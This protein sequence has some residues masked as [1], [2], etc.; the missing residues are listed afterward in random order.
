MTSQDY[1]SKEES[2]L[3]KKIQDYQN[4]TFHN[5]FLAPQKHLHLSYYKDQNKRI[6]VLHNKR[7]GQ[8]GTE[9]FKYLHNKKSGQ[10]GTEGFKFT[11]AI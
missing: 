4:I 7:S 6:V 8:T 1:F 11:S 3:T 10:T 9:G 5:N 2:L